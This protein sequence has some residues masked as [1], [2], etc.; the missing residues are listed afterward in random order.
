VSAGFR[1]AEY[2]PILLTKSLPAMHQNVEGRP[3]VPKR[4]AIFVVEDDPSMLKGVDRLLKHSGFKS[5][6]FDSIDDFNNRARLHEAAC[7]VLD[8]NLHG[9]SGIELS[10]QLASSG[11]SLPVIFIT[12]NDSEL[13][14]KAAV[15]AGCV[16]Y[17]RKPFAAKS[18][19]DAVEKAVAEP[20]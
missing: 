14:R 6:L 3:T 20:R 2:H 10:R 15:E 17:L 11:V 5:Q 12:A 8:I 1:C 19:I 7:I 18:L 9:K 16:A 13:N 4:K